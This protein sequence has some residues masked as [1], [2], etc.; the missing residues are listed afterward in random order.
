MK[1]STPSATFTRPADTTAYADGDLVANSTTA[2][3][4]TALTFAVPDEGFPLGRIRAVRITKSDTDLTNAGFN[5]HFFSASQT[6]AN[7]DNGAFS[8][9]GHDE[10]LGKIAVTVD[11]SFTTDDVGRGAA[12][13]NAEIPFAITDGSGATLYGYVEA[14]AAYTPASAEVFVVYP[15]VVHG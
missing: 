4:V 14:T 8:P 12:A 10:W 13:V 11:D 6:V 3:S 1:V 2:G 9:G 15:E 5:V 7:G